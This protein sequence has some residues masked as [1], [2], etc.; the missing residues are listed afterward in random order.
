ARRKDPVVLAKRVHEPRRRERRIPRI[1]RQIVQTRSPEGSNLPQRGMVD[2][3][4]SRGEH[5]FRPL[6]P[7]NGHEPST[8][9]MQPGWAVSTIVPVDYPNE[10][11]RGKRGF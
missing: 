9:F 8:E 11:I 3:R 7:T 4:N 10:P 6:G 1:V 5:P 2:G